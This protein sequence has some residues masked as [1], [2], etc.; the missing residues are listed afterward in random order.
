[1]AET[2]EQLEAERDKLRADLDAKTAEV[3]NLRGQLA[4]SGANRPGVA[5]VQHQFVL[6]QAQLM[7]LESTGF[8]LV[9]GVQTSAADVRKMLGKDQRGITINE[10]KTPITPIPVRERQ[11]AVPGVDFVYPSVAPGQ[12]DPAVAGTPGISG[13]AAD[14]A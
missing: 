14:K 3:E 10:P 12:I 1:M 2:K 8:T 7:E 9:D 11:A 13:P 4:A 5:P 6:N